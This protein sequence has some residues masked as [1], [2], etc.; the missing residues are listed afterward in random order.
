MNGGVR[1]YVYYGS[2]DRRYTGLVGT[3]M[4]MSFSP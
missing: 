2:H 4:A 3:R 1:T